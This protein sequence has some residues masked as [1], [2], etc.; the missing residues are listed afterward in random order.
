MRTDIS[1]LS[2]DFSRGA[3]LGRGELISERNADFSCGADGSP[4]ADVSA[5]ILER[6]FPFPEHTSIRLQMRGALS[7][8]AGQAVAQLGMS[9]SRAA[10]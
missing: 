10:A 2:E 1:P 6:G 9:L 7:C 4:G 8:G 3:T 5:I